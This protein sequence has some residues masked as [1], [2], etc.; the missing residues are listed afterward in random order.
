MSFVGVLLLAL[1]LPSLLKL[2]NSAA[3]F[4]VGAE[5][6]LAAITVDTERVLGPLQKNW[7]ALAQGGD[8]LRGFMNG[9]EDKL[10]DLDLEYIRIDHIYDEFNV[11]SKT[12]GSITYD[13]S[14]LDSLI[15][16][17]ISVGAKPFFSLSYM[18]KDLASGGDMLS[19]P[20]DWNDWSSLVQKTIEHY[21]GDLGIED[22]Y[23]EVWNEPDLFGK[24]K[25][26]GKKDYRV[27]YSY[28]VK[29]AMNATGV[30]N[31]KI[32][33]AAT[34]GLYK[35]WIDAFFPYIMQNKLRLDFF[36]W[37]RYDLNLQKYVDDVK[38][39]GVWMD[40]YPFFVQ[41]ERIISELGPN[42]EKGAENDTNVGAA[43]LVAVARELMPKVKYGFN[44]AVAGNW[45]I[46]G[47]PRYDAMNYLTK[48]GDYRLPV[49]GEGTW[50]K[51]IAAKDGDKYQVVLVNY[52]AKN[53]HSEVVPVTFVN[54]NNV[55]YKLSVEMLGG[56]KQIKDV[57]TSEAIWQTSIPLSA[58]SVAF[59][60]MEPDN[61]S[62]INSQN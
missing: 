1:I 32:G 35:N 26:G 55:K 45:G 51:A 54:L 19:E 36:S 37:H 27:L 6:R 7:Q 56:T 58:N 46:I 53:V 38:N 59:L 41:T 2:A 10:R 40:K 57:A 61:G 42:S 15:N 23:Y 30:K 13:W 14:N 34:T 25:M 9:S 20:A 12:G 4:I 43:H 62:L 22:V 60:E 39:T 44:F 31:F 3:R 47:K 17:I 33:G 49:S 8:N 5:G 52:D 18:P 48:L 11:V 28:A 29:G 21:S 16:Q 24:W 50:V